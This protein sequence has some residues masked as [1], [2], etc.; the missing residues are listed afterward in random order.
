MFSWLRC[1]LVGSPPDILT[2]VQ[3]LEVSRRC[4]IGATRL[5]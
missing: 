2:L 1:N 5:R 3:G 4:L